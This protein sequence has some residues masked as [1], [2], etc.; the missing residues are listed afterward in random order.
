MFFVWTHGHM[1][2]VVISGHMDTW[3]TF[4]I[5]VIFRV[6]WYV[7]MDFVSLCRGCG[8]VFFCLFKGWRCLLSDTLVKC[9]KMC[10]F[11]SSVSN[12]CFVCFRVFCSCF[13]VFLIM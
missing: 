8:N 4:I 3:D 5:S 6:W 2:T 7:E 12:A 9:V 11:V 13:C 10:R 1:D